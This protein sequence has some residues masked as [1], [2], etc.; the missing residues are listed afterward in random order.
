MAIYFIVIIVQSNS[1]P[2]LVAVGGL[3]LRG[4]PLGC[5]CSCW[6][7]DCSVL[8]KAVTD[9]PL[10]LVAVANILDSEAV[11]EVGRTAA[12]LGVAGVEIVVAE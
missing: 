1:L 12:D 11:A 7:M 2:L 5:R 10:E 4:M 6:D 3:V 8:V 9:I